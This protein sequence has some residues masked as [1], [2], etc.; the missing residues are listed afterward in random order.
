MDRT[1]A[2]VRLLQRMLKS[3]S[4]SLARSMDMNLDGGDGTDDG[5]F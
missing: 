1:G 4:L 2:G 3:Q 5:W